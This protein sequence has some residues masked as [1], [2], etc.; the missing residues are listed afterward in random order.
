MPSLS[1]G[2]IK[3]SIS[4][5]AI[6]NYTY[7]HKYA[8][9]LRPPMELSRLSFVSKHPITKRTHHF[10]ILPIFNLRYITNNYTL[11]LTQLMLKLVT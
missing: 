1:K 11:C 9:L 10:L 2:H 4:F 6:L 8:A 5:K 3:L 7:V